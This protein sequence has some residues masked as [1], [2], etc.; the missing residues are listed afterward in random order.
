MLNY[1]YNYTGYYYYNHMEITSLVMNDVYL[2]Y[3]DS[4][5]LSARA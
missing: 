4:F 2:G 5:I 3:I 1:Y